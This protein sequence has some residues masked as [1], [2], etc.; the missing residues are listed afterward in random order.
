M[1]AAKAKITED[2]REVALEGIRRLALATNGLQAF[3]FFQEL[4]VSA[5][6]I[7]AQCL[8][9]NKRNSC[10][11][12]VKEVR[13]FRSNL[14]SNFGS[15]YLFKQT[16]RYV[17]LDTTLQN[18]LTESQ[19]EHEEDYKEMIRAINLQFNQRGKQN[20]FKTL[21]QFQIAHDIATKYRPDLK[22]QTIIKIKQ[23]Q[24]VLIEMIKIIKTNMTPLS[25]EN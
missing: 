24:V 11:Y 18:L 2:N 7:Q 15:H 8:E 14:M 12:F 22:P 16:E 10:L 9:S 19:T 6:L 13:S 4:L 23:I 17:E 5:N 25:L 21:N 20:A 3:E 1:I